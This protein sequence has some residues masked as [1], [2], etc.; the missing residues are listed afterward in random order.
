MRVIK[1]EGHVIAKADKRPVVRVIKREGRDW[2]VMYR[3]GEDPIETMMVFGAA[4]IDIALS[5]AH[6]SLGA[7][8]TTYRIVGITEVAD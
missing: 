7:S 5:D 6:Y 3:I 2:T 1:R 8:G 4:T